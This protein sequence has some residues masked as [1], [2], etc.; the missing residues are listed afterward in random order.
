MPETEL[1]AQLDGLGLAASV[2]RRTLAGSG[3]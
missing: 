3:W 2:V 1:H